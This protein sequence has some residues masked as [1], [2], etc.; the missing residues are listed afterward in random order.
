MTVAAAP[1]FLDRHHF[2]LKRLHSLSG[3]VPIGAFLVNHLLTNSTAFLGAEHFDE[4]VH[5]IHSMPWLLAIEVLF[6]FLPLAFHA[7]YGVLIALE[8]KSNVGNYPYMDNWRY[9]LQ[10]ITAW[11]TLAFIVVHLFHYRFAHWLGGT[12]YFDGSEKMGAFAFT[13]EGLQNL[14]L[15]MSVWI[16]LYLVGL[17]C[18]VYHFCNGLVTFCITWGITIGDEARRRVSLGAAGFGVVLTLWGL[19]SLYALATARVT[20]KDLHAT[21]AVAHVE[22]GK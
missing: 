6:I 22:D 11:I 4:H 9:Y 13:V 18:A 17:V 3:I 5:W 2:L 15:P 16:I 19:A 10:R 20:A 14:W 7:G 21:P 12:N 1:S 8:G